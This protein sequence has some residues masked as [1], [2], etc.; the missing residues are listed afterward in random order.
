RFP[1]RFLLST[2]SR[3]GNACDSQRAAADRSN[4]AGSPSPTGSIAAARPT[5]ERR[6][7]Q[8]STRTGQVVA[9]LSRRPRIDR[10]PGRF[11]A[12][13][14]ERHSPGGAFHS[15][16]RL[17]APDDADGLELSRHRAP[18][19]IKARGDFVLGE[20]FHLPNGN[21]AQR[22][23]AEQVEEVLILLGDLGRK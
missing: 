6:W 8:S 12:P 23:I 1:G 15:W 10:R 19:A 14:L 2:S 21:S 13:G 18:R 3:P 9:P 4:D 5:A 20:T 22:F 7:L 16:R 11:V 17:P